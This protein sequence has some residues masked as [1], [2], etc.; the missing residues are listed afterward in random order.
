MKPREMKKKKWSKSSNQN[1]KKRILPDEA[2]K[3]RAEIRGQ[4]RD[5]DRE[6]KKEKKKKPLGCHLKTKLNLMPVL[7]WRGGNAS[8]PVSIKERSIIQLV[9]Y[10]IIDFLSRKKNDKAKRKETEYQNPI[11]KIPTLS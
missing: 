10:L 8:D 7:L 9:H 6:G 1:Q 3:Q 4:G 11:I 2:E 5:R